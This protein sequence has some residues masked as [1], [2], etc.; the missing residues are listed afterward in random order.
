MSRVDRSCCLQS[1]LSFAL[2]VGC[3][4]A[5]GFAGG[6]V[7]LGGHDNRVVEA[8]SAVFEIQTPRSSL[9]KYSSAVCKLGKLLKCLKCLRLRG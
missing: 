9:G 2:V 6:L 5:F 4:F 1:T 3:V 7:V 8:I